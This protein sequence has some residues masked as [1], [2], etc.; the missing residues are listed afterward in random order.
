M[1]APKIR[2]H[3]IA[4]TNGIKRSKFEST[5]NKFKGLI[6]EWVIVCRRR[7]RRH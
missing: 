4:V 7:R 1:N 6:T 5:A 3:M 2:L